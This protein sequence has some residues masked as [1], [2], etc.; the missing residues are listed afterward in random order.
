MVLIVGLGNPGKQYEHNRHN[1]GFLAVDHLR[2]HKSEWS[3]SNWTEQRKTNAITCDGR[4][5]KHKVVLAKPQTYMNRSGV[6]IRA[7][8]HW[9]D[10]LAEDLVVIHDDLDIAPGEVRVQFD[11]SAAGHNGVLSVIH[12]IGTKAFWRIRIG[13]GRHP[14][15]PT[16]KYVLGNLSLLERMKLRGILNQLPILIEEK[17]LR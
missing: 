1:V 7:L 3:C 6:S 2:R 17:F 14:R 13:I 11:K 8:L 4:M 10:A 5:G 16:E 12:E 15:I 9:H